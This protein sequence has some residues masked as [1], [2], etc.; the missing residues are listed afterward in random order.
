MAFTDR[1][2]WGSV[3]RADLAGN[4]YNFHCPVYPAG[5][6]EDVSLLQH[7]VYL[8]MVHARIH[9]N[10]EP[11]S[12]GLPGYSTDEYLQSFYC[13]GHYGGKTR[14]AVMYLEYAFRSGRLGLHNVVPDGIVRPVPRGEK[15]SAQT[16]AF[17]KL[18]LLNHSALF[19]AEEAGD[20]AMYHEM[21]EHPLT[22]ANVQVMLQNNVLD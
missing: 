21:P 6:G 14:R 16:G 3:G 13:D 7:L 20:L 11:A 12:I 18:G 5:A 8:G 22:P 4:F 10:I 17:Y 9:R 1:G 15:V 19:C 2:Y